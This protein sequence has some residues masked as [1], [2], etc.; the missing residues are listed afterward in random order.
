MKKAL[1]ILTVII[2]IGC[3]EEENPQI[4]NRITESVDFTIDGVSRSFVKEYT[5][6]NLNSFSRSTYTAIG[7]DLSDDGI[8]FGIHLDSDFE[9]ELN[10]L[11]EDNEKRSFIESTLSSLDGSFVRINSVLNDDL[12]CCFVCNGEFQSQG[13]S[14][15]LFENASDCESKEIWSSTYDYQTSSHL[16]LINITNLVNPNPTNQS[17]TNNLIMATFNFHCTAYNNEGEQ[18]SISGAI[19]VPIHAY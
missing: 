5:W 13:F 10:S 4:E 19:I 11:T 6:E 7:D 16:E 18:R 14:V 12:E 17:Q 2:V 9:K 3:S 15:N 1:T 8:W